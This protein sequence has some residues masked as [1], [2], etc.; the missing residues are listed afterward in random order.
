MAKIENF[1]NIE[2]WKSAREATKQIYLLS[3][4]GEFSRDFGLRDQ[5]RRSSVSIMSN[6]A[7]GFEREGNREFLNFL[8][9]AKGSCA[10]ARA[11]LYVALDQ[12]YI[13][14]DQFDKTYEL[15][16]GTGRLIGGFMRYLK[17]SDFKGNKFR[18][19]E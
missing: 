3:S 7:E 5:I 6:I 19:H 12:Q 18:Q 16:S 1:E 10:E 11:Q 15:L 9:I 2:A 17:S 14:P 13:Q 4:A 8:S